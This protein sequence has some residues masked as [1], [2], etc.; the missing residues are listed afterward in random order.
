MAGPTATRRLPPCTPAGI[1]PRVTASFVPPRV[2]RRLRTVAEAVFSGTD[3]PPPAER[4]TWLANEFE[5]YLNRAGTRARLIFRL[6]LWAV[7]ML[8]PL[9]VGRLPGLHRLAL[10]TRVRALTKM[11]E[12]F[13]SGAVLAVKAF[14]CV[15]YY[16]HP[17]VQR[18]VGYV[19]FAVHGTAELL[20]GTPAVAPAPPAAAAP[21]VQA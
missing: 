10:A 20:T 14:M 6:A 7:V 15:L 11:E 13:L 1:V 8:A 9:F 17:E 18:E 19:G 3:G 12:S 21:E 5:D 4:I 2:I 16:E